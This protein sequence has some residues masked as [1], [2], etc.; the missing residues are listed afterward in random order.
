[1]KE[2]QKEGNSFLPFPW[3]VALTNN[4]LPQDDVAN[5]T[6]VFQE[7]RLACN[8]RKNLSSTTNRQ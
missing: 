5:K 2:Y 8:K 3:R 6:S 4:Q 7:K 1:M